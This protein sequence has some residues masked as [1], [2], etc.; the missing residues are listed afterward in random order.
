MRHTSGFSVDPSSPPPLCRW[1]HFFG[2]NS[3]NKT[4]KST[5][6]VTR[7]GFTLLPELLPKHAKWNIRLRITTQRGQSACQFDKKRYAK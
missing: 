4:L 3:G 2:G 1:S 7:Y 6:I 5:E